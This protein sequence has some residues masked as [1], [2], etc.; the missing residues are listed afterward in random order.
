MKA[1]ALFALSCDN[2][3]IGRQS[4]QLTVKILNGTQPT[5]LP[6][7][8]PTKIR[9]AIGSFSVLDL[10]YGVCFW[11]EVTYS[12]LLLLFST[13]LLLQAFIRSLYLYRGQ[14][15]TLL[16][17][18]LVP[19]AGDAL[20]LSGLS[21]FLHLDLAPLTFAFTGLVVSW[22]LFR[23]QLLDIVPVARDVVIE[24]MSDG[25]IV[26]DAQD[27]IVD[28]NPAA[29][30]IIGRTAS[31]VIGQPAAQTLSDCPDLIKHYRGVTKAHVEMAIGEGQAQRYF[32][33][34]I[35]PLYDL[36]GR[37]TG[38]LV[39]LRDI[40]EHKRAEEKEKQRVC[41]LEF[42][43]KTAMEFIELSPEQDIYRFIG[44]RLKE[45]VGDSIVAVNSFDGI[46]DKLCTHV[47]L[48]IGD[49][50]D[51]VLKIFGRDMVG[52]T[53]E[54]DDEAKA[55]LISRKLT[56][57]PGGIYGLSPGM[58]KIVCHM[59]ERLLGLGDV[60]AVGFSW[61]G[62]L[63]GGV[64]ILLRRKTEL[65]NQSIIE[66]F[67]RQASVALQ[68]NRAEEELRKAHDEL[69]IRVQERTAEL[70]KAN[71]ALRAEI[72]ERKQA[73]EALQESNRRLEEA[74]VNLDEKNKELQS[75]VYTVSH[76]L[77]APLVS[78]EGFASILLDNYKESI[79]E[80]GQLY[81]LRIQANVENMG[82]LIQDLLELSRIGR[83]VH[84]Y[85]SMDVTE[86]IKEAIETLEIQLSERGTE[87]V[88]QEDLPTIT[89]DRVRIKQVFENL[90]DN[91]NKFMG[92][93]ND[94]PRIEIGF[95]TQATQPRGF[96]EAEDFF[97]FFVKDNGIGI[98][99]E[100]H[101]KVFNLFARLGDVEVE[102]TGVGLAIV[103][104]IV[105]THGGKIWLDS[106]VGKGTT[107]YFTL[108]KGA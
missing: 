41:D 20:Y 10:T 67:V 9:L 74:L 8:V 49:K 71:E 83:I 93:E 89:C 82:N 81:L 4:G 17:G 106:E 2:A 68:R 84:D 79:D 40:T 5:H 99:K 77:K 16:I 86:I 63:F 45:L 31:E 92:E 25:V 73:E 90:I 76:D 37:L 36:R 29:Q 95:D 39:T 50:M 97:E 87:W 54:I 66:T 35:S 51:N 3:D 101:E 56:K 27:R 11:V 60:Y 42:L 6:V 14:A 32:D 108:P 26:L 72:T 65:I 78:L 53:F 7:T 34:R 57:V 61:G 70:S 22:G 55:G 62:K 98:Q 75:F 59:L 64:A 38:R 103:K 91:A 102:G 43:S 58:P 107:V 19:W 104:K 24:S 12:Y 44:E 13:L 96:H 88:V 1:G 80:T 52:A 30:Y 21:P 69:E 28:L 100:Y 23:Y 94:K 105:E 47:L 85:E 18:A 48:G 15:S 46:S 33:P